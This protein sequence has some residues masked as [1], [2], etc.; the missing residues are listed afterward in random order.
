MY[1]NGIKAHMSGNIP[2]V[3]NNTPHPALTAGFF[4]GRM[5]VYTQKGSFTNDYI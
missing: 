3:R 5:L 4:F 2:P 1:M